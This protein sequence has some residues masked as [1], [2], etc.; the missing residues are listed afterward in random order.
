VAADQNNE[1]EDNGLR[2]AL[3]DKIGRLEQER[4]SAISAKNAEMQK[5]AHENKT[6]FEDIKSKE[7]DIR[8]LQRE[9]EVAK[10]TI[11]KL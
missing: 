10:S 6:K 8:K 3:E 4:L 1:V 2:K 11:S 5:L 9:L 7:A